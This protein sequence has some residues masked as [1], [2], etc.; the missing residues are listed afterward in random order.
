[1]QHCN[2]CALIKKAL[3]NIK[4]H[5]HFHINDETA[6]APRIYGIIDMDGW[7]FSLPH[8]LN[9]SDRAHIEDDSE[10]DALKEKLNFLSA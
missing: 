9:P 2:T 7:E 3:E 1:M 5:G 4:T 6:S 10:K 8:F